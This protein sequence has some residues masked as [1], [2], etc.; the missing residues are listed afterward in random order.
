MRTNIRIGLFYYRFI[1][2][3]ENDCYRLHEYKMHI[4]GKYQSK[5]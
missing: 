4:N 1:I 3:K 2:G 5:I